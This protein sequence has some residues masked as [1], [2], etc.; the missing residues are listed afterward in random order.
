MSPGINDHLRSTGAFPKSNR[1]SDRNRERDRAANQNSNCRRAPRA[2]A[3]H[4]NNLFQLDWH[5]ACE[6]IQTSSRSTPVTSARTAKNSNARPSAPIASYDLPDIGLYNAYSQLYP[7]IH[8]LEDLTPWLKMTSP[9]DQRTQSPPNLTAKPTNTDKMPER[10]QVEGRLNQI[11]EYIKVTSTMMDSLS[12]SSDPRAQAQHDKLSKMVED[13]YDSEVKLSKLME[14]CQKY[15][16]PAENGELE[17]GEDVREQELRKKVEESQHKLAQLQEHQAQ[18]VGMQLRVR[19]RLNEA[20]QA[21]QALLVDDEEEEEGEEHIQGA[22]EQPNQ[23]NVDQLERETEV[24]RGKLQQLE[25]KKRHMDHLM[26]ELQAVEHIE[27]ASCSSESSRTTGQRDKVAEL[28]AMKAQLSYLKA[29]MNNATGEREPVD[30]IQNSG[31]ELVEDEPP[32]INGGVDDVYQLEENHS[33]EYNDLDETVKPKRSELPSVEQIQG[34]MLQAVTRELKEQQLMLQAARDELRRLKQSNGNPQAPPS[35]TSSTPPLSQATLVEKKQSNHTASNNGTV[36]QQAQNKC[37]QLEDLMRKDQITG[38]SVNQNGGPEW[39][40]RRNSTSQ[41]SHTSTTPGNLWPPPVNHDTAPH[42]PSVDGISTA[43]NLLEL[44]SQ[45]PME[46]G[47]PGNF[48]SMPAMLANQPPQAGAVAGSAEYYRQLLLGSQA[49]QLQLMST[50]VQQC[51][52]LLW[53]Q[54]RE[55]QSM[56][57]A[58]TQLQAQLRQSH[59]RTSNN[60]TEEQHSNLGRPAQP[61]FDV[62]PLPPSSSLP[63]LVS[64]PTSSPAPPPVNCHHPQPQL[65]QPQQQQQQPPQLNNQVPPGNR[66]NN[67]WDNF[68]SYSRQNLLSGSSKTVTDHATVASSTSSSNTASGS[69]ASNKCNRQQGLDSHLPSG[70]AQYSLNLQQIPQEERNNY[71]PMNEASSSQ[72][73]Q[74]PEHSRVDE[75]VTSYRRQPRLRDKDSCARIAKKIAGRD[76]L[77]HIL[78]QCLNVL[79]SRKLDESPLPSSNASNTT[80]SSDDE[81]EAGAR[82]STTLPS[83]I[84][85]FNSDNQVST[86]ELI[87]TASLAPIMHYPTHQQVSEQNETSDTYSLGDTIE[88]YYHPMSS[89]SM[90]VSSS[91]QVHNDAT[92]PDIITQ[93][94]SNNNQQTNC[95]SP[96]VDPVDSTNPD[97]AAAAISILTL[98]ELKAEEERDR[99]EYVMLERTPTS[100]Q[101]HRSRCSPRMDHLQK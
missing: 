14:D 95:D 45:P 20:R 72:Q 79:E 61:H 94:A 46:N 93:E 100:Q 86:S 70:D 13:L 32:I 4:A 51:C 84:G 34:R 43:E 75:A 55:M 27:R 25:N 52:Q 1:R 38:L 58:I 59:S 30:G 65:Q 62:T 50:T 5:P 68:R 37:W 73:Q 101:P 97:E 92:E 91:T 63:N 57:A 83:A 82:G 41:H 56:R 10:G 49:Q 47:F 31:P 96:Y 15:W 87:D 48:W 9:V 8:A 36:R 89:L 74:Q 85:N 81:S 22:E 29:L 11:R 18:L 42:H 60:N 98:D 7:N 99:A 33:N 12:Q 28:E 53:S 77:R 76:D 71:V 54:Q 16:R 44:G 64:L 6:L 26:Q 35:L 88:K 23:G 80:D 67:Y 21:Q 90:T 66:A 40:S 39:G 69:H 3:Q 2:Q 19:E 17:N 24:L 78:M